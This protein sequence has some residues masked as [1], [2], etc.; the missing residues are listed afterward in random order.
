MK[1][2]TGLSPT[3]I[4]SGEST[5]KI[6]DVVGVIAYAITPEPLSVIVPL[7]SVP[8]CV[9]IIVGGV[10]STKVAYNVLFAVINHLPSSSVQFITFG[11]IV[12]SAFII[13]IPD[14]VLHP[15]NAL[16]KRVA[17]GIIPGVEFLIPVN[18]PNSPFL[19]YNEL[20]PTKVPPFALNNN[21]ALFIFD[22]VVN[23]LGTTT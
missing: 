4:H 12:P 22:V 14:C 16:P 20:D 2:A 13:L 17:V 15:S 8:D 1:L 11:I 7:T 23:V 10:L 5:S 19:T 18:T 3:D 6:D 9:A 21:L